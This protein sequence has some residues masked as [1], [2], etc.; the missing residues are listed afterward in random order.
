MSFL[1]SF[2][3]PLVC[4]ATASCSSF[5]VILL[6]G[7]LLSASALAP[8]SSLACHLVPTLLPCSSR[9]DGQVPLLSGLVP[10]SGVGVLYGGIAIHVHF[11]LANCPPCPRSWYFSHTPGPDNTPPVRSPYHFRP[12]L[13]LRKHSL[14]YRVLLRDP[15]LRAKNIATRCQR[16]QYANLSRPYAGARC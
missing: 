8:D 10:L 16:V 4:S 13:L 3:W 1:L 5:C 11:R 15:A 12:G 9:S 7:C 14:G 2:L 6:G